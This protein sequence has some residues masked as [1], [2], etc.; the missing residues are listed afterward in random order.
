MPR[1][2]AFS[3]GQVA[4]RL[5]GGFAGILRFPILQADR[6]IWM[7]STL[8]HR[9][10]EAPPISAQAAERYACTHRPLGSDR[11]ALWLTAALPRPAAC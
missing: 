1:A 6:S 7:A 5:S 9:Y 2:W 4:V 11:E 10:R 3:R 8:T